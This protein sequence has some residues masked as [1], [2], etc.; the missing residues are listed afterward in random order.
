MVAARWGDMAPRMQALNKHASQ[1]GDL[2]HKGPSMQKRLKSLLW[3]RSVA[4]ACLL[5]KK[6]S[7]AAW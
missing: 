3:V 6:Y 4:A 5:V 1:K 7:A 2:G